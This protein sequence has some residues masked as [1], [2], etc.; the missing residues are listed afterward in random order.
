MYI[1]KYTDAYIYI[2]IYIYIYCTIIESACLSKAIPAGNYMFKV[3][4]RNTRTWC[5]ICS[6][7]KIKIPEQRLSRRYVAFIVNFEHI[8]HL[9][10][11]YLL[12]TLN[13]KLP[14]GNLSHKARSL[15]S[16]I[17][18]IDSFSYTSVDFTISRMLCKFPLI[19]FT[20][21]SFTQNLT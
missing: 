5:E 11:V 13:M 3:N 20:H 17:R 16:S 15:S 1:D 2:Y 12:L 6:K 21:F 7:L 10:L 18:T 4:S 14:A 19:S 8:L 9:V